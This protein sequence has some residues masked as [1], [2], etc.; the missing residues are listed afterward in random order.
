MHLLVGI[1][2]FMAWKHLIS[3]NLVLWRNVSRLQIW[4]TELKANINQTDRHTKCHCAAVIVV[5]TA[6]EKG[7]RHSVG[8]SGALEC[9][10]LIQYIIRW[11]S[12]RPNF[13][14]NTSIEMY[15]WF[16]SGVQI[17]QTWPTKSKIE[18]RSSSWWLVW[19]STEYEAAL[20]H[21]LHRQQ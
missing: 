14:V 5:E 17:W 21:S 11:H 10:N 18:H 15:I 9:E 3:N 16:L 13:A 7:R 1:D 8:S 4:P 2:P 12:C 19:H 6:E 20:L